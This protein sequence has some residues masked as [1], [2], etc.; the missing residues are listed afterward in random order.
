[1]SMDSK[2]I[3]FAGLLADVRSCN[4]CPRLKGRTQVLSDRNGSL[5]ARVLFVAEAPG[6]LGADRYGIPLYGD[7]TGRNFEALL[8]AAGWRRE[9]VFATNALLCNPR[10]EIGN[11]NKPS[12][13]EIRNC[14]R[15]LERTIEIVSP[16]IVVTLGKQA[17]AA[18]S[19]IEAHSLE[20]KHHVGNDMS[21]RGIRL[22]P[23]YHP[24]QQVCNIH[25]NLQ[26]QQKDFQRLRALVT[27]L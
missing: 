21:W 7:Q 8:A 19:I 2:T 20:L 22:V 5:D 16:K 6:R 1:M 9:Q 23:L 11:N 10:D 4:Q 27:D 18:V 15:F 13:K 24:S 26:V 12:D 14:L 17:L 25:R 3:A